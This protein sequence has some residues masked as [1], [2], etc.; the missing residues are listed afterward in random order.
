MIA[1]LI[2]D[3]TGISSVGDDLG[4]ESC[5]YIGT[6]VG[7]DGCVYEI[8]FTSKRIL[9]YDPINDIASHVGEEFDKYF[10][11]NNAGAL[12]RDGCIY[13]LTKDGRVLKIDTTS[14]VHYF[15]GNITDSD[16]Y[17]QAN[18]WGNAILGIDGCIH[19]LPL[20]DTHTLKYD[21]HSNQTSLLVGDFG[22]NEI[23]KSKWISGA[24]AT[25]GIMSCIPSEAYQVLAIDPWG[26]V[27]ETTKAR[28]EDH[29]EKFGLLFQTIKADENS[30]PRDSLTNHA[31]VKFGQFKVFEVME[32]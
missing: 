32:K 3:A 5:K 24:L 15:V 22:R 9:K 11:C 21:P 14:N 29:P 23:N 2:N 28:M 7:I 18:G 6:V 10:H 4:N 13:A 19:W 20:N 8:P 16:H 27:L 31:V 25:D 30:V 12:G 26:E 17:G 1:L